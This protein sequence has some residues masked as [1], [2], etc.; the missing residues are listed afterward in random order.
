MKRL[1]PTALTLAAFFAA[2]ALYGQTRPPLPR[3]GTKPAPAKPTQAKPTVKPV[4]LPTPKPQTTPPK[5]APV[6][7][8][9][10]QKIEPP[11]KPLE[12]V[13][14]EDKDYYPYGKEM[15]YEST[16]K[17][18]LMTLKGDAQLLHKETKFLSDTVLYNKDTK[19]ASAPGK[20][21]MEDPQNTLTSESG[22]A[23]YKPE[24]RYADMTGDVKI[25]ARP[26]PDDPKATPKSL[27]KEFKNPVTITCDKLRYWWKQKR[28]FTDTNVKITFRHKEKD[29]TI[30]GGSLEYFGNDERAVLKGNVVAVN[31]K[32]ERILSD[33]ADIFF[34]EGAEK[35]LLTPV[36]LG[37]IIKGD[38]EDEGDG[39]P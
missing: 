27:R 10:V 29:W 8:K 15:T 36:K 31:D 22:V 24:L 2:A 34:K 18:T 21:R 4:V 38:K 37:T 25:I 14:N 16:S 9:V 19:I 7:Q 26:K 1:T 3:P 17:G 28:A 39:R 20:L 23:Y 12:P 30:T 32:G 35:L 11:A 6:A 13:N 5:T 33:N